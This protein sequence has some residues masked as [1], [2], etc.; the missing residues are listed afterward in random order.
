MFLF[1]A[2]EIDLNLTGFD[3]TTRSS[4]AYS[5]LPLSMGDTSRGPPRG[6]PEATD[7]SKASIYYVFS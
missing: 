5:S 6:T 7:S 1:E 2:T 3:L 4:S